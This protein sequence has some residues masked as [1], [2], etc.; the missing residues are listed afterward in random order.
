MT[1]RSRQ[2]MNFPEL[3]TFLP[4]RDTA[5]LYSRCLLPPDFMCITLAFELSALTPS[6]NSIGYQVPL[7]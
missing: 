5:A 3:L 2:F 7:Y 4:Q 1:R 6:L